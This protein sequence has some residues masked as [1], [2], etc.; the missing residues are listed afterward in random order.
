MGAPKLNQN[1]GLK[2]YKKLDGDQNSARL[3]QEIEAY[4]EKIN[5][6]LK[7]KDQLKKAILVI[8]QM[9]NKK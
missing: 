8:E 5:Q 4:R 3:K 6:M 7:N 9:I 2:E 1:L